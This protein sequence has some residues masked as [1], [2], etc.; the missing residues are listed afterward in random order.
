MERYWLICYDVSDPKRLRKVAKVMQN[1]GLRVQKSIFECWLSDS[2]LN[3]LRYGVDQIIDDR[4]DDV[5]YYS[6]CDSCRKLTVSK[7]KTVLRNRE[8]CYI[9]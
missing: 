4:E 1:F 3:E 6:L 9:V 2:R 7:T 8:N 5:R